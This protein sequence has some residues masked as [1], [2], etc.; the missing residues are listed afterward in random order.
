MRGLE[1]TKDTSRQL[2][3]VCKAVCEKDLQGL[4]SLYT[5]APR[6]APYF[7]D[8]ML[9]RLRIKRAVVMRAFSTPLSLREAA[10]LL[11]CDSNKEVSQQRCMLTQLCFSL[12][13]PL[14]LCA[15]TAARWCLCS[16]KLDRDI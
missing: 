5:D 1:K 2:L 15:L 9:E 8:H 7:M 13:Q 10:D 14:L 3:Q 12:E 11:C 4:V 6:M 16:F